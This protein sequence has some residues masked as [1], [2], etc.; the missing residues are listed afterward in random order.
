MWGQGASDG[1]GGSKHSLGLGKFIHWGLIINKWLTGN[2]FMCVLSPSWVKCTPLEGG[3]L[4]VMVPTVFC[5]SYCSWPWIAVEGAG[6]VMGIR[7]PVWLQRGVL[8]E[9]PSKE[10]PQLTGEA[11][12]AG[13]QR[14][15]DDTCQRQIWF[16]SS[17]CALCIVEHTFGRF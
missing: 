5:V 6:C 9:F 8:Q 10:I 13:R 2:L 14:I 4:N 17:Y 15:R 3:V 1:M 16:V 7:F 12:G 11:W